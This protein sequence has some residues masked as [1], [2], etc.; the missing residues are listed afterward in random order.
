MTRSLKP[1]APAWWE[2]IL[3]RPDLIYKLFIVFSIFLYILSVAILSQADR[4]V[5]GI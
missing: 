2:P 3:S 1:R 5:G 4:G